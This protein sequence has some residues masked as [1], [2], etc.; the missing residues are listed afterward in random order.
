M[1]VGVCLLVRLDTTL[2]ESLIV[3]LDTRLDVAQ[4]NA[5]VIVLS[6]QVSVRKKV[7][8]KLKNLVFFYANLLYIITVNT[9]KKPLNVSNYLSKIRPH[10]FKVLEYYRYV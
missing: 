3:R 9:T 5:E 7:L 6:T 4:Q 1:D 8:L 10:R 2:V